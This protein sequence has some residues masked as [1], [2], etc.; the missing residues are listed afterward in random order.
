MVP[1]VVYRAADLRGRLPFAAVCVGDPKPGEALPEPD[2]PVVP[3][4]A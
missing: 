4:A 3:L 2:V 1:P